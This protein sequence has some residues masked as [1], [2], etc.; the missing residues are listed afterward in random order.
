MNAHRTFALRPN[1]MRL[2]CGAKLEGSQT[3]FYNTECG[4]DTDVFEH[5]RRQLQALVRLRTTSHSSGPSLAGSTRSTHRSWPRAG[6]VMPNGPNAS[7]SRARHRAPHPTGLSLDSALGSNRTTLIN[8]GSNLGAD[9]VGV[10]NR[11][12]LWL[13]C[14]A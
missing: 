5:G 13:G 4:R 1:E 14:A 10:H 9:H 2:S 11:I 12:G 6:T 8:A 7:S 3:E